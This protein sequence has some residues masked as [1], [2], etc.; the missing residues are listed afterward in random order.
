MPTQRNN[1]EALWGGGEGWGCQVVRLQKLPRVKTFLAMVVA[2]A[3][4]Q[5]TV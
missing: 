2:T 1:N 3:V 5:L 4:S